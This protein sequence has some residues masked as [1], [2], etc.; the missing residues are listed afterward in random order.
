MSHVKLTVSQLILYTEGTEH[1]RA[2]PLEPKPSSYVP[3]I[4]ILICMLHEFQAQSF[5]LN[6]HLLALHS[7]CIEFPKTET[8]RDQTPMQ[9]QIINIPVEYKRS[10]V[11]V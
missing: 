3:F 1:A 6:I 11:A 5:C 7:I 9:I 4:R 10:E 8:N 2:A